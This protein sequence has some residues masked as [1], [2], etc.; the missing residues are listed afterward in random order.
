VIAAVATGGYFAY[1]YYDTNKRKKAEA[2]AAKKREAVTKNAAGVH[3]SGDDP[4]STAKVAAPGVDGGSA[5]SAEEPPPTHKVVEIAVPDLTGLTPDK[6][7]AALTKLGFK[8]DALE[9]PPGYGCEYED[10]RNLVAVGAI[11]NQERTPGSKVMSNAKVRVVIEHDTWE[12]GGAHLENPWRRMPDLSGMSLARAQQILR[13]KGFGA[14][15]FVVGES[16]EDCGVG[17]V[18]DQRPKP[19]TRKFASAPGELN[20]D[21]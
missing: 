15:E 5:G 3:P 20:V 21:R 17:L 6:A 11:C 16:R 2:A 19:N 14:D 7:R 12:S 13:E 10:E 4:P 18:C 9:T 8:D 1:D